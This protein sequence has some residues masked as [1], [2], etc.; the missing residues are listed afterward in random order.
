MKFSTLNAQ[1]RSALAALSNSGPLK[2]DQLARVMGVGEP[3]QAA[4]ILSTMRKAGLIFSWVKQT[5][6]Y[7][8]W[9]V[10]TIGE[11]LFANRPNHTLVYV[12]D[13]ELALLT[14]L[15]VGADAHEITQFAVVSNFN[16]SATGTKEQAMLAAEEIALRTGVQHTVIGLVAQ[17]TPPEQPRAQIT[18]L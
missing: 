13:E 6:S 7:A 15:K 11:Q 12:N 4:T 10:S 14:K 2:T 1:H 5:G 8:T 3:K 16:G 9:E 17:V 18:L